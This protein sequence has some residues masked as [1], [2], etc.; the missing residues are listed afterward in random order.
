MQ[1]EVLKLLNEI[2]DE[3]G[4]TV[5]FITHDLRVAAQI[6]DNLVVM[7]NGEIVER[8]NVDEVFGHPKH[9]YTKKLLSAQPGQNWKVPDI[10][11]L[12]PVDPALLEQALNQS[13]GAVR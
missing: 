3:M 12:P 11:K 9:D 1:K 2:R 13:M 8:G 10:S 4:L 6:C 5:L 7:Q